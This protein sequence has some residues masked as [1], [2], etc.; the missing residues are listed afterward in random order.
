MKFR[1]SCGE[2]EKFEGNCNFLFTAPSAELHC[3]QIK[4]CGKR[5]GVDGNPSIE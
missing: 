1:I 4:V 2:N 5:G 3:P